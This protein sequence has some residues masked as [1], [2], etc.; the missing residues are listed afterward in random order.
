VGSGVIRKLGGWGKGLGEERDEIVGRRVGRQSGR[1]KLL[2]CL[3][4]G[5]S[6][7]R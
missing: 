5:S 7:I 1:P 2:E 3:G 4:L 6:S